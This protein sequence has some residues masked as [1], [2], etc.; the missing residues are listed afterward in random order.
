MRCEY[1]NKY[2]R[3]RINPKFIGSYILVCSESCLMNVLTSKDNAIDK[4]MLTLTKTD[5]KYRSQLEELFASWLMAKNISYS[6]EAYKIYTPYG[7]YVP[8]FYIEGF[9]F[10]EL[11]GIWRDSAWGKFKDAQNKFK[12]VYAIPDDLL[13]RILP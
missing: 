12:Y 2:F 1:C 13:R 6:Q 4:T 11:K 7:W 5:Y 9:G 10:I 3:Y 8:D